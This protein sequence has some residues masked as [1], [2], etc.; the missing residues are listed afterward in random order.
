MNLN[1]LLLALA[2]PVPA[3]S[4]ILC[5]ENQER[6]V[7]MDVTGRSLA[8][9]GL[10]ETS[11]RDEVTSRLGPM[12]RYGPASAI[13]LVGLP[14]GDELWLSFDADEPHFLTRAVL[15]SAAPGARARILFNRIARTIERKPEALDFDP[16]LTDADVDAIWGPPDSVTGSGIDTWT[17]SLAGGKVALLVF[18]GGKLVS[19][20]IVTP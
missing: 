11:T 2:W 5:G 9:F 8:D 16:H 14:S 6:N 4:G 1:A 13:D 19:R 7:S 18:G 17:Y 3:V 15:V 20:R 10:S 12:L